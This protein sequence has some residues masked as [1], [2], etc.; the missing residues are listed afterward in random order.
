MKH[1]A[2]PSI[3]VLVSSLVFAQANTEEHTGHHPEG[4]ASGAVA[5]PSP[6]AQPSTND[7][8]T[9]QM[10]MMQDM[11]KRMQAA[12]TPAEKQAVM[13]DQMKLMQSGVQMMSE[14]RQGSGG[15]GMGGTGGTPSTGMAGIQPKQ[16]GA[17]GMGGMGGMMAMHGAMEQ[18]MAM[19]E[20]IVQMM[21]DREA[22][23][24]RR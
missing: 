4:S 18:R 20:Q 15:M 17:D 8:F 5:V 22:A 1:T 23:M 12:K 3:F 2:I 6:G 13:R 7:Q 19:M 9:R 16:Q 21:V 14:M 24:P 10:Q 11:H